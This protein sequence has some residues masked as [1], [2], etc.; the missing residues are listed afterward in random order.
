MNTKN[1]GNLLAN[2]KLIFAVI[3]LILILI[4]AGLGFIFLNINVEKADG[5]GILYEKSERWG[6]CPQSDLSKCF[7][8]TRIYYDGTVQITG[9]TESEKKISKTEIEQISN[10][11]RTV[12]IMNKFCREEEV[13]D[14][15][16]R[17]TISIDHF[18]KRVTY[19]GCESELK[20][21]D[22]FIIT[23]I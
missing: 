13:M 9:G 11:I 21:I 18:S 19:N 6:P 23:K 14:Y 2:K 4:I 10:K 16:V 7:K 5:S 20:E 8:Q 17:Y 3:A 15:T 22:E 12:G 1:V